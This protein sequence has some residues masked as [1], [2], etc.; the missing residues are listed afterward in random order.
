MLSIYATAL[1]PPSVRW[2]DGW[3]RAGDNLAA[4]LL[5]QTEYRSELKL[6]GSTKSNLFKL[7]PPPPPMKEES[8][9]VHNTLKN[10]CAYY[11]LHSDVIVEPL[12]VPQ[13]TIQSKALYRTISFL[14]FYNLKNL[15]P[16]KT[17]CATEMF[18]RC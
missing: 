6:S 9:H 2:L 16:Q 7:P 1:S 11:V 15:F 17:F 5:Y 4:G 3:C 14:P 10:V 12:L 18:F 13:R 8:C